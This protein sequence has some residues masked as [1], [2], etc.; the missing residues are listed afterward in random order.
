MI[1][2]SIRLH[3]TTKPVAKKKTRSHLHFAVFVMNDLGDEPSTVSTRIPVTIITGFLGSG[4]TTLI[5][6]LVK[7]CSG[8]KIAVIQNEV[9]EEMGIESAIVT[10]S[11]GNIIPD[12]YELPNGCVCCSAKDDMILALENIINLGRQRIDAVVVETTGVADPCSVAEL[13]WLDGELGS[14]LELDGVVAVVDSLNFQDIIADDHSLNHSE[15]GRRQV[16]VADRILI[17]KTDLVSD[18]STIRKLIQSLNPSA[19]IIETSRSNVSADWV[20]NIGS[21]SAKRAVDLLDHS[22]HVLSTVDHVFMKFPADT[23]FD[24]KSLERS[25][26]EILWGER[27]EHGEVYRIKGLFRSSP[28]DWNMIQAVGALFETTPTIPTDRSSDSK[29]LFIGSNLN[30]EL[31]KQTISLAILGTS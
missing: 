11:D 13:F 1:D 28:T 29:F 15:I 8:K 10:D 31:L 3:M 24:A 9:S 20:L 22:S 7:E 12:F 6:R 18:T 2:R 14:S 16:A 23:V 5:S 25:L 27:P 17:N 30:K 4:K 21:F 19:E 26:G